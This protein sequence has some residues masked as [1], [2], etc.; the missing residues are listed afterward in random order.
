MVSRLG[1]TVVVIAFGVFLV[2]AAQDRG[3]LLSGTVVSALGE[4]IPYTYA[5]LHAAL[6]P[7]KVYKAE[8]DG[9]GQY[10]FSGLPAGDYM[11]KLES[12]GFRSLTVKVDR[13]G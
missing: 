9:Q 7:A 12:P 6:S 1:N 8:A 11:L 2:L 13:F 10:R 4:R 3:A 5:V